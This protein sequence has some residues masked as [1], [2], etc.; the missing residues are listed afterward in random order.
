MPALPPRIPFG[1]VVGGRYRIDELLGEGGFGVVFQANQ[2]ALD[3]PVALKLLRP[4]AF[5]EDSLARFQREALIFQRLDHPNIVRL[6]DFGNDGPNGSPYLVFEL[7]HGRT[8]E[9]MLRARG[10]L[11]PA[12]IVRVVSQLLKALMEA[13]AQGVVHRDLKPAN[14]FLSDF[15]GEPDFVKI[16]DFGLAKGEGARTL[17]QQGGVVGTVAYM[18]PEQADGRAVGPPA[19]LFAVGLVLSEMASGR[20]VFA[21]YDL[22]GVVATLESPDPIPHRPEALASLFGT[23]IRRATEKVLDRRYASAREMLSDLET[24]PLP[25]S[26]RASDPVGLPVGPPLVLAPPAG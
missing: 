16:I 1:T 5:S 18:A 25:A 11:P 9:A 8:L 24:I 14:V 19:D 7:L 15:Q 17:T 2:L 21:G 12:R 13:H 6:L 20:P 26:P 4:Q 3:R 22:P 10:P 23:V